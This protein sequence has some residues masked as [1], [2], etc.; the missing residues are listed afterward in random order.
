MRSSLIN[1]VGSRG[2]RAPRLRSTAPAPANWEELV[3][4]ALQRIA[5]AATAYDIPTDRVYCADET[6]TSFTPDSKCALNVY[7]CDV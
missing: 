7:K 6:Y 4:T 5:A 2:A 1:S 3:D